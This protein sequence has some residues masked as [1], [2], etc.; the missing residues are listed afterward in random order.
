MRPDE[1]FAEVCEVVE[2]KDDVS[3]EGLVPKIDLDLGIRS[4]PVRDFT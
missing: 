3:E 1:G 4:E 2:A